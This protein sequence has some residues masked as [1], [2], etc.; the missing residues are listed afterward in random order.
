[1]GEADIIRTGRIEALINPV[2]TKIALG[3]GLSIFVK[4]NGMVRAFI[5]TKLTPSAFLIVKDDDPV[6]PFHYGFHWTCLC[7][8]RILAVFADIHTPHEIELPVHQFR[9]I[10][11]NRQVLDTIGCIDWIIFLFARYFTGLTSPAGELFDN[12]RI[13][14]SWLTSWYNLR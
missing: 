11:P 12:E 4:A 9:A 1:M 14:C 3:Y 7:T 2:M 6:F 8:G 13:T 10:S 5:D